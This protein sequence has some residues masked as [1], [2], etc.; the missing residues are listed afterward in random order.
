MKPKKSLSNKILKIT[1]LILTAVIIFFATALI[2]SNN[3]LKTSDYT[4]DLKDLSFATYGR[5]SAPTGQN[6]IMFG[7]SHDGTANST[8]RIC[9]RKVVFRQ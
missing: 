6:F 8:Y 5:D 4:V 2:I 9:L 7:G 1:A 3:C